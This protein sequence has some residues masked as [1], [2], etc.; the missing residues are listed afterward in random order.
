MIAAKT[1]FNALPIFSPPIL[2]VREPLF[3][4]WCAISYYINVI[5]YKYEK[6]AKILSVRKFDILL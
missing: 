6:S 1:A 3:I 2:S 4:I 5:T